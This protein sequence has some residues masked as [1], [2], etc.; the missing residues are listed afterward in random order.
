[1]ELASKRKS[2]QTASRL[3]RRGVVAAVIAVAV[4]T[5]AVVYLRG[6]TEPAVVNEVLRLASSAAS[7][8]SRAVSTLEGTPVSLARYELDGTRVVLARSAVPFPMP[9][10]GVALGRG[11]GEPWLARRGAMSLLCFS[12]PEHVMVAGRLPPSKLLS[13]ARGLGLNP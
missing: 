5:S 2:E 12:R 7:V 3:L 9:E 6:P 4:A 8:P 10:H 11:P 13:F 1:V